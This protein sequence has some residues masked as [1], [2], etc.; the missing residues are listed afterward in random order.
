MVSIRRQQP[1]KYLNVSDHFLCL[2][3]K[4]LKMYWENQPI[5]E[6]TNGGKKFGKVPALEKQGHFP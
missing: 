3:L 6:I 1:T 5:F 4:G 2:A